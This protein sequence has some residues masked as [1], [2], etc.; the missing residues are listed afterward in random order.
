MSD[1]DS[2]TRRNESPPCTCEPWSN[3]TDA[4]LH[5]L[6]TQIKVGVF[7]TCYRDIQIG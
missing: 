1:R 3:A 5:V 4:L 6:I 7:Q 2:V